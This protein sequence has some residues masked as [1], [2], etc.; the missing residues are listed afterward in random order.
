MRDYFRN[1]AIGENKRARTRGLLLDSAI[2]V[3]SEKGIEEASI[4][5]ITASAGLANG[6]FY[7]HFKGKDDLAL[8]SAGAIAF[9]IAKQLDQQLSDLERGVARIAV[10]SWAFILISYNAGAWAQ[11]LVSQYQ[12]RPGGHVSAFNYMQADI[13]LALKQGDLDVEVDDF[14]LEQIA[15]LMMAALRRML[16]T[17][18]SGDVPGKTCEHILRLLGMTPGQAKNEVEK[19]SQY[20]LLKSL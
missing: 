1:Q 15:S 12:R 6:T 7:N 13:E 18:K 20:P 10:A 17:D 19:A 9:E 16:Q 2:V 3:F 4:N 11:V 5:E 8:A 14:L